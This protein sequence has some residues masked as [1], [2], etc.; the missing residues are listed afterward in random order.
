VRSEGNNA[1][2]STVMVVV[3]VHELPWLG[4]LG[5]RHLPRAG[6]GSGSDFHR[7]NGT[8]ESS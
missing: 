2:G 6:P 4:E 1:P 7:Q 3:S 5:D 8:L